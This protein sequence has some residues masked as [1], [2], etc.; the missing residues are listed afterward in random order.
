M[1][2]KACKL[3]R[4]DAKIGVLIIHQNTSVVSIISQHLVGKRDKIKTNDAVKQKRLHVGLDSGLIV[5]SFP[6]LHHCSR[7]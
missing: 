5:I 4:I 7:L 3:T 6:T 1:D 2:L